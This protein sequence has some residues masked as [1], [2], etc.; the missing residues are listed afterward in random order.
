MVNMSQSRKKAGKNRR[1]LKG[2]ASLT[3]FYCCVVGA[4]ACLIFCSFSVNMAMK[5]IQKSM[6]KHLK[7][8]TWCN[9]CSSS[10]RLW[11]DVG[12]NLCQI[13]PDIYQ[14]LNNVSLKFSFLFPMNPNP[15]IKISL[16]NGIKNMFPQLGETGYDFFYLTYDSLLLE[17]CRKLP[18]EIS[19]LPG[20]P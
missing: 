14:K 9:S 3:M 20:R 13:G 7:W 1:S 18:P 8:Q 5:I 2:L 11:L 16:R 15:G 17:C 10:D 12:P 6:K 4:T 19:G